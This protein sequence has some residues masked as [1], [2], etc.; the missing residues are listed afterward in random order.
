MYMNWGISTANGDGAAMAW[1][2][3]AKLGNVGTQS[4]NEGLPVEFHDM[5]DFDI[6]TGNCLYANLVYEPMLR[7]SHET[8]RRISDETIMYTPHFQAIAHDQ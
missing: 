2:A 8:G 5:F 6:T 4:H 7:V 3:G 1:E